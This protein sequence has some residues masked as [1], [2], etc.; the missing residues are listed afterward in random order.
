MQYCLTF[1]CSQMFWVDNGNKNNLPIF[2][3]ANLDGTGRSKIYSVVKMPDTPRSVVTA[4][5]IDY[6]AGKLYW[7]DRGYQQLNSINLDGR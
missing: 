3:K 5:S 2:E 7:V 1:V 4:I 6:S